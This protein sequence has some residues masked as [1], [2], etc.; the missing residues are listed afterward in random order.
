MES[1]IVVAPTGLPA[2]L[3]EDKRLEQLAQHGPVLEQRVG[4]EPEQRAGDAR[5][6][7]VAL[8]GLDQPAD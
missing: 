7:D 2:Q 3:L 8:R 5:V 1:D 6:P 4:I